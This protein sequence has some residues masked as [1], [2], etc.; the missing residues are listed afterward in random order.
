MVQRNGLLRKRAV[1]FFCL[2][3]FAAA[4][5]DKLPFGYTK[6]GDIVKNPAAFDGKEL[7]IQ[8]KVVEV[9]KLPLIEKKFFNLDDGTGQILVTTEQNVPGMG[10]KVAVRVRVKSIAIKDTKSIALHATEIKRL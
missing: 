5:C 8:G 2:F 9:T 1:L 7:K 4:A 3:I 10:E 6:I